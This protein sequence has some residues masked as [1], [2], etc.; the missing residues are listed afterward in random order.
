MISFPPLA[1]FV[2]RT[3]TDV[4]PSLTMSS[5]RA[6]GSRGGKK[7]CCLG[8]SGHSPQLK[9]GPGVY[10]RCDAAA[11]VLGRHTRTVRDS[12]PAPSWPV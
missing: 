7:C 10:F 5:G 12:A 8:E 9:Q 2:F 4:A 3:P 1:W 11:S 6:G